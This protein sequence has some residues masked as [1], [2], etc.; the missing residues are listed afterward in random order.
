[1]RSGN[2]IWLV[3]FVT[4]QFIVGARLPSASDDM[5]YFIFHLRTAK[6]SVRQSATHSYEQLLPFWLKARPAVYDKQH[7]V[8]IIKN[9]YAEHSSLMKH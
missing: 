6:L 8:R 1:M 9:P 2:N 7:V 3:R 5:R 4:E